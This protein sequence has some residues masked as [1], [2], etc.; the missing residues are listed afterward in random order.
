MSL[1]DKSNE[2]YHDPFRQRAHIDTGYEFIKRCFSKKDIN[3]KQKHHCVKVNNH[4]GM[5]R[6]G[7]GVEW[8]DEYA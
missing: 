1:D 3:E 8:K 6:C 7:C 5:H 2:E 4:G